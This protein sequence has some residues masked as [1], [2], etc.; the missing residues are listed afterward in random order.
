MELTERQYKEKRHEVL[1]KFTPEFVGKCYAFD[2]EFHAIVEVLIR[3]GNPYS[4]IEAL[5]NHR[6]KFEKKMEHN[7]LYGYNLN[8]PSEDYKRWNELMENNGAGYLSL[9]KNIP[10]LTE[11]NENSNGTGA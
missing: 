10:D 8:I 6:V 11:L 3:G 9:I 7:L 4:I 2:P 5:I 1:S